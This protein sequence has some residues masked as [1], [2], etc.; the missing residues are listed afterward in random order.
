MAFFEHSYERPARKHF[1]WWHNCAL[2]RRL[3]PMVEK[4]RMIRRRFD[5]IV[6]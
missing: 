6:T 4:A 2:R 3:A 1:R 5:N